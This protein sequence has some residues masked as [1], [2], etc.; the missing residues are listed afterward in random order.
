MEVNSR[1]TFH[2]ARIVKEILLPSRFLSAF[3]EI[4]ENSLNFSSMK[5]IMKICDKIIFALSASTEKKN[6]FQQLS[7]LKQN[8]HKKIIKVN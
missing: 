7:Q 4:S 8:Y 2:Y 5:I 6:N 1:E 3:S